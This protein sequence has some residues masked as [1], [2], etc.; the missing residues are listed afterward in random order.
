MPQ[1]TWPGYSGLTRWPSSYNQTAVQTQVSDA[2]PYLLCC[3]PFCSCLHHLKT[4]VYRNLRTLPEAMIS[5]WLWHRRPVVC[6]RIFSHIW[7]QVGLIQAGRKYSAIWIKFKQVL[8]EVVLSRGVVF[9][10]QLLQHW[11]QNR[12]LQLIQTICGETGCFKPVVSFT[13]HL[14]F[15]CPPSQRDLWRAREKA[16][17]LNCNVFSENRNWSN[18]FMLSDRKKKT[19]I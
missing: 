5:S 12:H 8:S 1:P 4:Q 18:T 16:L 19:D 9:L 14:F 6:S 10:A 13:T 17:Q 3:C 11:N 2:I 7:R 15:N